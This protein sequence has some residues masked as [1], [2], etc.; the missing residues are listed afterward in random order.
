MFAWRIFQFLI[1]A[2]AVSWLLLFFRSPGNLQ[3]LKLRLPSHAEIVAK[4]RGEAAHAGGGEDQ[5]QAVI[6]RGRNSLAGVIAAPAAKP[7]GIQ[8]CSALIAQGDRITNPI[9][10]NNITT[11]DAGIKCRL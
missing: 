2:A 6:N 9:Y 5:F 10:I 1:L 7:V 4:M 11:S 3:N 8:K